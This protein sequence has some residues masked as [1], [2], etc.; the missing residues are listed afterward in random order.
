MLGEVETFSRKDLKE[1]EETKFS[2]LKS[3]APEV[4][5]SQV[6]DIAHDGGETPQPTEIMNDDKDG[7]AQASNYEYPSNWYS[8]HDQLQ[9]I[10]ECLKQKVIPSGYFLRHMSGELL[11]MPHCVLG[12]ARI[13][14]ICGVMGKNTTITN[15]DLTN[16]GLGDE[17][18][19]DLCNMFKDNNTIVEVNL[20]E[21]KL[22]SKCA[23]NLCD[24][25]ASSTQLERIDLHGN[26][27]DDN[28]GVYFAELMSTSLG[29]S[30]LNLSFNDF[31]EMSVVQIGRALPQAT[32]LTELDLSWNRL[33]WG[34]MRP[35]ARGLAEN[36]YL[37]TLNLSFNGIGPRKGCP[38]LALALKGNKTLENLDIS[39]NRISPEGAVLLSKGLYSNTTL[40]RIKLCRNPLQTA[41][42]FA[43]L[44][45]LLRNVNSGLRE[46]DLS[47]IPVNNDFRDLQDTARR[48]LPNLVVRAGKFTTDKVRAISAKLLMSNPSPKYII[49]TMGHVTGHT[50]GSMLR[51]LDTT[52]DKLVTRQAFIRVLNEYL[53]KIG[54]EF[55]EEQITQ[56]LEEVDPQ[57]EEEIDFR[58][59]E[60]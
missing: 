35:F 46:L 55:T 33:G 36:K 12:S 17:S 38:E 25:L 39:G 53:A 18:V 1:E 45:G 58:D 8:D 60:I 2:Q 22:T 15:L 56:L 3:S 59:F 37:K 26:K 40:R 5:N 11:K 13:R 20:S 49:Q 43:L 28:A 41:G 6:N 57:N 27:F 31:G 4:D 32:S 51:P 24:V 48:T 50:L 9:Y 10:S 47:G 54:L 44:T 7:D 30:Y 29:M 14:P 16:A 21:N 19:P 34:A 23:E 52:G 42:C